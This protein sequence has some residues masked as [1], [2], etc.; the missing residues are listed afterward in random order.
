MSNK[1]S[2]IAVVGLSAVCLG[3]LWNQKNASRD[4]PVDEVAVERPAGAPETR[5]V[6]EKYGRGTVSVSS[7]EVRKFVADEYKVHFQ[8]SQKNKDKNKALAR[9]E[10]SR[11]KI[12]ALFEKQGIEKKNYE[13]ASVNVSEN[14]KYI[15]KKRVSDGYVATQ[16][17]NVKFSSKEKVESLEQELA[18][19]PF[20]ENVFSTGHLKNAE[21]MEQETVK[22]VCKKA[23]E[24]AEEYAH[25]VGAKVGTVVT[26]EGSSRVSDFNYSDSVQVRANV[27]ASIRL[28]GKNQSKNA[29][30]TVNQEER[31]KFLAD[32]FVI[33]PRIYVD[34]KDKELLYKM[35]AE[36]RNQIETLAKDL[37]V[38][39]SEIDV[40]ALH[41][42]KKGEWELRNQEGAKNPIVADQEIVVNFTSKDG[43]VAF[44]SALTEIENVQPGFPQP[45]LRNEDSLR[46]EVTNIAGAKALTRAKALAEG[47]G[48]KLGDVVNVGDHR[49]YDY[50]DMVLNEVVYENGLP[51][52]GASGRGMK[53]KSSIMNIA[54]SVEI[55]S[56]ISVVTELKF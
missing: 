20:V 7:Q 1:V 25:S 51:S 31:K 32:K 21:V 52:G 29:F 10:E 43:A 44:Y 53:A 3:L 39:P 33:T 28:L 34:G 35:V 9:L 40:H 8:I 23:M 47:F 4:V 15:N 50:D 54:D 18:A 12:L 26:V 24:R 5:P 41:I 56:F 38:A 42:R 37:G 27:D 13:H 11:E 22:G 48:G 6:V 17:I 14:W 16:H 55:Y 19:I 49:S 30:I 46:V 45:T 36:K 2:A